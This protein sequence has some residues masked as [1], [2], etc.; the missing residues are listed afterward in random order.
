M[1]SKNS[2]ISSEF[3]EVWDGEQRHLIVFQ[4]RESGLENIVKMTEVLA[5][6]LQRAAPA[7]EP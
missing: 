7:N 3:A 2:R 6:E 1:V 5:G 4:Q